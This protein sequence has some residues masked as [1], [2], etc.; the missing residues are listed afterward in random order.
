[1]H[2]SLSDPGKIFSGTFPQKTLANCFLCRMGMS[3]KN[4]N[5]R[6]AV[7]PKIYPCLSRS[8]YLLV[9]YIC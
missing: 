8:F 3:Q 9:L 6:S 7:F 4:L 5:K 2:Y 1:M